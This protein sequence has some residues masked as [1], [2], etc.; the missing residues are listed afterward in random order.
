TKRQRTYV[1]R[2]IVGLKMSD[3]YRT[4][5]SSMIF[6]CKI[7]EK[8]SQNNETLYVVATQNGII[9][10]RFDQMAFLDILQQRI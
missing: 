1:I 8:N 10:E 6:P 3:V 2:D 4:N 9:K 7:I 5:T